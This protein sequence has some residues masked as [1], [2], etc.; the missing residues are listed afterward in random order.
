M[1]RTATTT[2]HRAKKC[3]PTL[4]GGGLLCLEN[5]TWFIIA[6]L[7][8]SIIYL[9]Y[10][11]IYKPSSLKSGTGSGTGS[12][13]EWNT[14]SSL[15][16]AITV[17]VP[18]ISDPYIPPLKS[19]DV[20]GQPPIPVKV[21]YPAAVGQMGTGLGTVVVPG[22]PRYGVPPEMA[23]AMPVNISTSSA[24]MPYQQIGILT[25]TVQSN[26]IDGLEPTI[27]P[28]M[29]RNL[30]NGRDKWQYYTVS[31]TNNSV[32]LPVSV[33]GK[34]CTNEYGCDGIY[35]G[36]TIYVEGYDDTFKATIYENSTLRYIPL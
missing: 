1:K 20:R 11:L 10:T 36:D 32:R 9:Y 4:F 14:Y 16:P 34:S 22:V 30:M 26:R 7:S 24:D 15:Y 2:Y 29:G 33:K 3:V 6:I 5:I 17:G 21:N 12:S 31:N 23:V 13:S 27:L 28:L 8:I 25:K 19:P 18:S 35:N